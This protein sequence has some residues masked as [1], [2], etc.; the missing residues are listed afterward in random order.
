M[1]PDQDALALCRKP[2]KSE[3]AQLTSALD[4]HRVVTPRNTKNCTV[5]EKTTEGLNVVIFNSVEHFSVAFKRHVE[6][7]MKAH[8]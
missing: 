7:N 8:R 2:F 4:S 5:E 3:H 1:Q 6:M